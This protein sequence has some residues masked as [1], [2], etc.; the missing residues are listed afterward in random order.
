MMPFSQ[1]GLEQLRVRALITL[2]IATVTSLLG[3]NPTGFMPNGKL[4]E[5]RRSH[6]ALALIILGNHPYVMRKSG[7]D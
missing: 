3:R 5:L 1:V 2:D 6:N 7:Q 4:L